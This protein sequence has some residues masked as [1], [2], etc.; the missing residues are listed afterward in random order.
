ML[1]ITLHTIVI[2]QVYLNDILSNQLLSASFYVKNFL[3]PDNYSANFQGI[4]LY[5][6]YTKY[7]YWIVL[8]RF[9]KFIT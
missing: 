7:I 4:Y 2:F 8:L 3:D 5:T 1:L 6:T 9:S